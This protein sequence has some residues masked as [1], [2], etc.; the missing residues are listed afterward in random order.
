MQ[1]QADEMMPVTQPHG[2][3]PEQQVGTEVERTAEHLGEELADRERGVGRAA[4][5]NA[6]GLPVAQASGDE[7]WFF[8]FTAE[9]DQKRIRL[10]PDIPDGRGVVGLIGREIL[11]QPH[12]LLRR[13]PS[14]RTHAD[15]P[16]KA[17]FRQVPGPGGRDSGAAVVPELGTILGISRPRARTWRT[18]RKPVVGI[19]QSSCNGDVSTVVPPVLVRTTSATTI[20]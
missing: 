16:Q 15:L 7:T 4:H 9:I 5:V 17:N 20:S 13:R 19:G 12:R 18:L 8:A 10:A 14:D 2:P 1:D 6:E 11:F 3:D